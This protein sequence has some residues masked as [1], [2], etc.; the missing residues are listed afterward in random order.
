VEI[1][2]VVVVIAVLVAVAV[3]SMRS[4]EKE[5][6]RNPQAKAASDDSLLFMSS[7]S[8]AG[9]SSHGH[10]SIAAIPTMPDAMSGMVVSMAPMAAL[11]VADTISK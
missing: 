11:T 7:G 8:D 1:L 10:A 4:Y 5:R 9:H 3:Q 6:L 2:L